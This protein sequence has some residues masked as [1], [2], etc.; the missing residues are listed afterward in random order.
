MGMDTLNVTAGKDAK[1]YRLWYKLNED[2]DIA[3]KTSQVREKGATGQSV[4]EEGVLEEKL[5]ETCN[6]KWRQ[7][8]WRIVLVSKYLIYLYSLDF[9]DCNN[10][11]NNM[12]KMHRALVM[13]SMG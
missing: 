8:I 5:C 3:V 12:L 1:S 9:V 13:Q 7:F 6:S 11:N 4:G 10:N 2:T